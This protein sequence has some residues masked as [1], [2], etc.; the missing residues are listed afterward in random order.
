MP[1]EAV[2]PPR[3]PPS[4][5]RN[6]ANRRCVLFAGAGL[7]AWAKLPTWRDLLTGM[8]E[9]VRAETLDDDHGELDRLIERGKYLELADHCR[10]QLGPR[11]TELL[12]DRLRA[13][14]GAIPEVHRLA[15]GMPFAAW[16][17]TNFDKLLERAYTEV[18]GGWPR[19]MTH[20]DADSLGMALFDGAPFIL[21]AHGDIDKPDS[22]VF[23]TRDYR[24]IIHAN[25]AFNA[26]FSAI[27]LTNAI[28]FVGYSLSDPDFRLLLD[29]QLTAFRTFVPDRYAIMPDVGE[30]E[31]EVLW[32]TARIKVLTYDSNQGHGWL[33]EFLHA[34]RDAVDAVAA[35]EQPAVTT[36]P[37][38]TRRRRAGGGTRILRRTLD[39]ERERPARSSVGHEQIRELRIELRAGRIDTR[40]VGPDGEVL[41]QGT[42]PDPDWPALVTELASVHGAGTEVRPEGITALLGAYLPPEVHDTLDELAGTEPAPPLRLVLAPRLARLPWEL[43]A[44]GGDMLSTRFCLVR[45]PVAI[46]DQARGA[47]TIR[48]PARALLIGD[49][50]TESLYPLPGARREVERIRDLLEDRG[51]PCTLLVGADATLARTVSELQSGQYDIL[52]FA[53]HAWYDELDVYLMLAGDARLT[54]AE[55]RPLCSRRPPALVFLDSHYTAF[56]PP[57]RETLSSGSG[58]QAMRAAQAGRMGFMDDLMLGGVGA[59]VGCFGSVTDEGAVEFAVRVHETLAENESIA[60]SVFNARRDALEELGGDLTPLLYA[61]SGYG[62]L[63]V[64]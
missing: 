59:F 32:R 63:Q 64:A 29:R 37:A 2:I 6:L 53:G 48:S 3:V 17:T 15:I 61:L 27:L 12:A 19:T 44:A 5:A 49:P 23:T 13:A 55:L 38:V 56:V 26:V 40:L 16:V 50:E 43:A 39:A 57:T 34:L 42:G 10:E 9:E 7:S 33:L 62:S 30:V 18:R 25:P 35:T 22:L 21:K 14:D 41:A 20:R 4:L 46:S 45:A 1:R 24:E 52:H 11:Y 8:V 60:R 58:D 51:Y 47:P 28:L 36:E 54:S 31:R